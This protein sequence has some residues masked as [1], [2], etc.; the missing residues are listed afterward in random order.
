MIR[1][2]MVLDKEGGSLLEM[3]FGECHSLSAEPSVISNFVSAMFMFGQSLNNQEIKN[4][5]FEHLYFMFYPLKEYIFLISVDDDFEAENRVKLERISELFMGQY[6]QG[7]PPPMN[8]STPPDYTEFIDL[9]IDLN[10]AQ[11]NCGAH[12]DCE[13]CPNHRVLPLD[14]IAEVFKDC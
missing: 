1:N 3:N 4:I 9:L 6:T 2:L 5:R 11:N 13:D 14:E 7:N 12:P 10:I 8:T